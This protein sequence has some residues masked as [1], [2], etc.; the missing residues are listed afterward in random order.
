MILQL[1]LAFVQRAPGDHA[2]RAV[3]EPVERVGGEPAAV[4]V[5]RHDGVTR[6]LVPA[7]PDPFGEVARGWMSL[8]LH[9]LAVALAGLAAAAPAVVG[10]VTLMAAR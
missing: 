4:L 5:L 1:D 7:D 8:A 6:V 9:P 2:D 3:P 10:V